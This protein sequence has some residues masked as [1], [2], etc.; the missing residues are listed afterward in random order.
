MA[1]VDSDLVFEALAHPYRR[2]LLDLLYEHDGQRLIDL[3]CHLPITRTGCMKHLR[4]LVKANLV[5]TRKAGRERFHYLNPVPIQQIYD[6]WM[7]KYSSSLTTTSPKVR[8]CLPSFH[9]T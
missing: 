3:Q 6:R 5:I 4:I 1:V 7:D 9:T 2:L 8:G